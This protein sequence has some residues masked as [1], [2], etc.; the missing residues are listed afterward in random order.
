MGGYS[1]LQ[2]N[3]KQT[4]NRS[5]EHQSFVG[6]NVWASIT[7]LCSNEANELLATFGESATMNQFEN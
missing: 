1:H 3:E 2:D 6:A 4:K 5:F 7:S